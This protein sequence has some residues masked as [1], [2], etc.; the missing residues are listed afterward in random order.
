[1]ITEVNFSNITDELLHF[2]GR[3][4]A[5]FSSAAFPLCKIEDEEFKIFSENATVKSYGCIYGRNRTMR[6]TLIPSMRLLRQK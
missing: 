3:A 1:M 2:E 6:Y 4:I 5:Y